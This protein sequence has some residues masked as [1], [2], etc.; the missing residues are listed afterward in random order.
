MSSGTRYATL[1]VLGTWGVYIVC[2]L[3]G[4]QFSLDNNVLSCLVKNN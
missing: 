3:V 4:S 2:S 1:E